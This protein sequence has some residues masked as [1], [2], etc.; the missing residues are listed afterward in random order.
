MVGKIYDEKF[1]KMAYG[2]IKRL[3][4]GGELGQCV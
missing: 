2:F 1:L 3:Y 4:E